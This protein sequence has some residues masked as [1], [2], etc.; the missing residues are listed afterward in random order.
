M[1]ANVVAA[2]WG[3]IVA[4]LILCW[5]LVKWRYVGPRLRCETK[6]D[7]APSNLKVIAVP[8]EP[9]VITSVSNYGDRPT[10]LTSFEAIV[11]LS[12]I[13]AILGRRGQKIDLSMAYYSNE[14]PFQ[15]E[16]GQQ[17]LGAIEYDNKYKVMRKQHL[18]FIVGHSANKRPCRCKLTRNGP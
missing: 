1:G 15:L 3:A 4:T 13:N 5:E 8:D 7:V 9:W 18:Y 12:R 14:L 16:S 2:W 11:Y 6:V 10:T 17:W